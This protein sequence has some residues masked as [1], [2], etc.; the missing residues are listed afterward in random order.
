MKALITGS[1][2][3]LG[4]YLVPELESN[5]YE[6]VKCSW[7]KLDGY[8]TMDILD[9]ERVR[10]VLT[11][12][13]PDVLFHLAGQSN[14]PI[15]WREPVMTMEVNAVGFIN[16][17][18]VVRE[19]D[20]QMRVVAIG[21]SDEYGNLKEAGSNVTENVV[22]NPMTPYAAS[23][24]AQENIGLLYNRAYK[25]NICMVRSFNHGAAHQIRG[26]MMTDFASGIAEIEAGKRDV[27]KVGNLDS[28]RDFTHAK[29][30]VRAYR[31]I[32]EKGH[33]GEVYNVGSGIPYKAK[34]ILDK[35]VALAKCEIRV[36][37]DPAR[38]RPS[39]TPVIR[40]NHDKLTEHTG[41][42]PELTMDDIVN[43]VLNDWRARVAAGE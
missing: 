34:E 15:S 30:A 39:D 12:E 1:E 10:E 2:G 3:F 20:P 5:G 33:A 36:E 18:D 19:I 13:K 26:F 7:P 41:W 25:M 37:P 27:L 23:K 8:V 22:V 35:M 9:R 24:V 4:H 40:C 29:D 28:S 6:V 42:K 11:A 14:V 32:A 38:M 43:D 21:S 16:I 17:L 31:L